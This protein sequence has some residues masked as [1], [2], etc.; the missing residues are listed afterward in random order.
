MDKNVT[1]A[2]L[3]NPNF[4]TN[5]VACP[6]CN[7]DSTIYTN[8][9]NKTYYACPQCKGVFL[10]PNA[11]PNSGAEKERYANHN[12]DINDEGYRNFVR[13][14]V[15]AVTQACAPGQ[16]GL[17]FGAGPGPVVST[18]LQEQGYSTVLYDPFF[19]NN[20]K[21]LERKYDY[22]ISCEVIEHFFHPARE[23]SL[24]HS[25][26]PLHGKLFC[27][28]SVFFEHIDFASWYYK[29]DAT[30]VFFY[31]PQTLHFICEKFAFAN[32]HV[33]QNLIIFTK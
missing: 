1:F 23:F 27:M 7:A 32:V 29:N 17:D 31:R 20:P 33:D 4:N 26:L 25:L 14:L 11:L 18:M 22:I 10:D 16:L 19:H 28:T 30:H 2:S 15:D 24:L 9:K 21:V 12:N 6:L 3:F 5:M 13:P 8:L